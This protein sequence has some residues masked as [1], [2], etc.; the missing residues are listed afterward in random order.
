MGL[1]YLVL[2]NNAN[3]LFPCHSIGLVQRHPDRPASSATQEGEEEL[4]PPPALLRAP[5]TVLRLPGSNLGNYR[6]NDYDF[7]LFSR[8]PSTATVT[9]PDSTTQSTDTDNDKTWP[10]G[11]RR[12]NYNMLCLTYILYRLTG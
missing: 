3:Y 10:D 6:Q 11:R 7:M 12:I 8:S 2:Q 9:T 4:P 1:P 5:A